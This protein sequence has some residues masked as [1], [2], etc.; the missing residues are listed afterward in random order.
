M[1][2]TPFGS[3]VFSS[4]VAQFAR[5]SANAR[6]ILVIDPVFELPPAL[7]GVSG[8]QVTVVKSSELSRD[9]LEDTQPDVVLVPLMAITADVYDVTAKLLKLGYTGRVRA[10]TRPLPNATLIRKEVCARFPAL[11]FG[12]IELPGRS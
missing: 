12:L 6:R 3:T 7:R 5:E 9:V 10:F 8:A 4:I 1:V 2:I 11:D